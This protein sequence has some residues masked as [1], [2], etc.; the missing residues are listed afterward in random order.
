M[1]EQIS[2]CRYASAERA[3]VNCLI[4]GRPS[5]VPVDDGNRHWRQ[6]VERALEIADPE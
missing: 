6:I 3:I 1:Q 2:D 4:D 5:S